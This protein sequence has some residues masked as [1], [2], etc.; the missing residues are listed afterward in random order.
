MFA[1]ADGDHRVLKTQPQK[2]WGFSFPRANPLDYRSLQIDLES[3]KLKNLV[4]ELPNANP[5][6]LADPTQ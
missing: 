3:S 5:I 1:V 4:V 2:Q 6:S